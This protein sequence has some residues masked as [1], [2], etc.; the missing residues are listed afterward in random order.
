MVLLCVLTTCVCFMAGH[1]SSSF[2][3]SLCELDHKEAG[4]S[5]C[6]FGVCIVDTASGIF[7]LGAFLDDTARYELFT[8]FSP[9]LTLSTNVSSWGFMC[10]MLWT[11]C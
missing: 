2:L 9:S 8:F 3:L 1:D 11:W 10:I 5:G 7:R 4:K 6:S